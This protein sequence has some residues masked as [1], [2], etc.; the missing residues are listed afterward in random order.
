MFQGSQ[1]DVAL[2]L[3][4]MQRKRVVGDGKGEGGGERRKGGSDWVVE[5]ERVKGGGGDSGGEGEADEAVA[6]EGVANKNENR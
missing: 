6:E 1:Q 2:H 5:E 4:C 3:S